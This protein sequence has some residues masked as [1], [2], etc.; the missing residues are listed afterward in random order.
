MGSVYFGVFSSSMREDVMGTVCVC[1]ERRVG[2]GE[3]GGWEMGE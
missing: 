3:A 1:V 2:F